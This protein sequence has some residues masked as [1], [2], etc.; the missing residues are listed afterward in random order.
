[1][2]G[3]FLANQGWSEFLRPNMKRD[4][5]VF[6]LNGERQVVR[7]I[8][9]FRTT[10]RY[11]REQLRKTGTKIVCEEGDCGACT[12][13]FASP[14]ETNG[15]LAFKSIDSCIFPVYGLDGGHLVTVEGLKE[16]EALHPVQKAMVENFGS[17][18]GYC[19]PG[20]VCSMAALT[21]ECK[22]SKKP[23]TEKKAKNFLTGNLCRCTGYEPIVKAALSVDLKKVELLRDR[24]DNEDQRQ[25]AKELINKPACI[26]TDNAILHL[27]TSLDQALK[28]KKDNPLIRIV[29]GATDLG[30]LQTK[31][32]F[33]PT[34]VMSLQHVAELYKI[35]KGKDFIE[36]GARVTLTQLEKY[37]EKAV[38]EFGNLLHIFAS[39]QIKNSATL[40]G[41]IVNASPIGDTI[42]YLMTADAVVVVKSA[43]GKREIPLENFY[44]GYKKLDLKE[45][46]LVVSVRIPQAKKNSLFKLYK[47]STRKDLDISTV[48]FAARVDHQKQ[49]IE[50]VRLV[51]GGVGP[52]VFRLEKL[53]KE[54]RK[55]SF[56]KALAE[57]SAR[58]LSQI[59]QPL[60]DVRGSKEYRLQ[61]SK[62][63]FRK[64]GQ[65]LSAE[66]GL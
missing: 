38:E 42:P 56:D 66:L 45:D 11:L 57:K 30:V 58:Q 31:G 53:E 63:L 14:Q 21:E 29:A 44:L 43:K 13:L 1:M 47:V 18:C 24:Y 4:F 60:S 50:D 10:A 7:G 35:N 20:M 61:L 22:S 17:Q 25:E 27:P 62:N 59:I 54:W 41:N 32:K 55:K 48:T 2:L 34:A 36:V 51:L 19:T 16:R 23:I 26:E 37:M 49:N 64:F 40:I 39:P 65:D 12:C 9:A 6:Y 28:I 52:T 5:L 33:A 15:K 3:N 8:D 46:E